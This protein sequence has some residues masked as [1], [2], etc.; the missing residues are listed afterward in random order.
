MAAEWTHIVRGGP[1]IE[2]RGLRCRIVTPA[3]TTSP[4]GVY[5]WPAGNGQVIILIEND[6]LDDADCEFCGPPSTETGWSCRIDRA[7]LVAIPPR[8]VPNEGV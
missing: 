1:W 5:P 6:P 3:E 2:R 4:P 8:R 7:D